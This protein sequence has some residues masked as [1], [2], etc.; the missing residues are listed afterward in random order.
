M[1]LYICIPGEITSFHVQGKPEGGCYGYFESKN[2]PTLHT[3]EPHR[4]ED[5][6][7]AVEGGVPRP[8]N[9]HL[10]NLLNTLQ[11]AP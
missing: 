9:F 4:K 1:Y 8:L 10:L 2:A 5:A 11:E 3:A 6:A 7:E